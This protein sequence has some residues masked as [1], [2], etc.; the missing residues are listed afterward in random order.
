MKFSEG[1]FNN[2]NK[3]LLKINRTKSKWC[4]GG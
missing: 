2:D 4:Y 3:A 1:G